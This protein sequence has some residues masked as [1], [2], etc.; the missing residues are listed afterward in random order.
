MSTE[1]T[2][3][4]PQNFGEIVKALHKRTQKTKCPTNAA[5]SS[6]KHCSTVLTAKVCQMPSTKR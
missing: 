3:F 5:Y 2:I 4:E 6:D 1:L